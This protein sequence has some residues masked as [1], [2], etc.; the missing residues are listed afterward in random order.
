[1]TFESLPIRRKVM[2]VVLATTVTAML[3]TAAAFT[4]YDLVTF[5]QNLKTNTRTLA[6]LTAETATPALA[7]ADEENTQ[8]ALSHLKAEQHIVAAAVYDS[9][10]HL[11]SRFPTNAPVE[12][13]PQ[14]PGRVGES[15]ANN[16]LVIWHPLVQEEK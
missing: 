7:F 1:M 11:Y 6:S 5:R 13:F 16:H 10:G 8:L 4:I 9:Q 15:F 3:L 12:D 14:A 2:A